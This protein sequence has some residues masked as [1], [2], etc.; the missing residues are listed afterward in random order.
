MS[1]LCSLLD[2]LRSPLRNLHREEFSDLKDQQLKAR[3]AL[4]KLQET[5]LRH[6][7]DHSLAI[8]EKEARERYISILSSSI[9]LIKQQSKMEWI[10]YGDDSTR[11]FY[12]K[13]KQRKLSSY[14]YAL[15]DH[16]GGQVEGFEEVDQTMFRYY[17]DMLVEQPTF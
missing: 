8:Q 4:E 5:S 1:S 14:I 12:A 13:A 11:L 17:K 16:E 10:K 3:N 6:P 15:K 2:R 7:D 9:D